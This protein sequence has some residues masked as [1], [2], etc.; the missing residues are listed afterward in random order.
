MATYSLRI[1]VKFFPH[2]D[3]KKNTGLRILTNNLYFIC[4]IT[5]YLSSSLEDCTMLT[6]GTVLY[7]AGVELSQAR[8]KAIYG[9]KYHYEHKT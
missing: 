7:A 3:W 6:H 8:W 2:R 4:C 5:L 9:T 1:V